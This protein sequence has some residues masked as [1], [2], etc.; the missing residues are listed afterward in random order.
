MA[1]V[2]SDVKTDAEAL[3]QLL[4]VDTRGLSATDIAEGAQAARRVS[5]CDRVSGARYL[6]PKAIADWKAWLK[7]IKTNDS[8]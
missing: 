1:G 8:H 4:G 3:L 7:R 5:Q 6:R 2:N